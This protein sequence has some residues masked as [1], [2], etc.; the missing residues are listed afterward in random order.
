[1]AGRERGRAYDAFISYSY[2]DDREVASALQRGL[3]RLAKRW[4]HKRA[5]WVFR[6]DTNLP[7]NSYLWEAIERGLRGSR[8]FLLMA[9]PEAAASRWVQQEV[10]F[11]QV[12][13]EAHTFLIA[14]TAGEIHWDEENGDFDWSRTTALP[15][16]LRGWFRK[17][18]LWVALREGRNDVGLSMD[19]AKFRAAICKLAA[20]MHGKDGVDPDDLDGEDIRQH[21]VVTRLLRAAVSVLALLMVVATGA[22]VVAYQQRHEALSQRDLAVRQRDIAQSRQLA[23]Q[24]DGLGQTRQNL[25]KQLEVMA[26]RIAPTTEAWSGLLAAVAMPMEAYLGFQDSFAWVSPDRTLLATAGESGTV[27]LWDLRAPDRSAPKGRIAVT[28]RAVAFS[29]D[30]RLLATGGGDNMVRLWDIADPARPAAAGDFN[31]QAVSLRFSPDGRSL[32]VGSGYELSAARVNLWSVGDPSHPQLA[33]S[34]IDGVAE[35]RNVPFSSDGRTLAVGATNGTIWLWDVSDPARLAVKAVL[36]GRLGGACSMEFDPDGS[37]LVVGGDDGKIGLWSV[38]RPAAA[39]VILDGHIES[40]C[41]TAFSPDGHRFVT[42]SRDGTARLWNIAGESGPATERTFQHGINVLAATFSADGREIITVSFDGRLRIW[43]LARDA[44]LMGLPGPVG[45][46]AIRPDGGTLATG[47]SE[48]VLLWDVTADYRPE[49]LATLRVHGGAVTAL[50]FSPDGRT[51]ATGGHDA[52]VILWDV[53]NPR[54]PVPLATVT[55]KEGSIWSLAFDP[56]GNLLSIAVDDG[57]RIFSVKNRGYPLA[58]GKVNVHLNVGAVIFA[59]RG[60]ILA[61]G[62][63]GSASVIDA[64]D[65]QTLRILVSFPDLGSRIGTATLSLDGQLLIFG[66]EDGR[67]RVFDLVD[68]V[69]P[70]LTASIGSRSNTPVAAMALSPDMTTLAVADPL[71]EIRLLDLRNR[72]LPQE[73]ATI[74]AGGHRQARQLKFDQRGRVYIQSEHAPPT[75]WDTSPGELIHRICSQVSGPIWEGDWGYYLPD[76]HYRSPC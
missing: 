72:F 25:A 15:E 3:H 28:A 20:P 14:V 35:V 59:Q 32:A 44:A 11:W 10:S 64:V 24:A 66:D 1:M 53:A 60:R 38:A 62:G 67:V 49:R 56:T 39:P 33:A 47:T 48:G 34:I 57:L 58:L 2:A 22:A 23:A 21:R 45:S 46:I 70:K 55:P 52:T 76:R 18:P 54:S 17:E 73:L 68:P 19:N 31:D 6:D 9:S 26:Y 37:A 65:P 13:K 63:D 51:L 12:N 41:T 36:H 50:A 29:P 42:S 8:F 43:P 61:V 71:G 5:L 69:H 27:S 40:A 74:S 4:Y 30:S 16:Q 75:S 7:A